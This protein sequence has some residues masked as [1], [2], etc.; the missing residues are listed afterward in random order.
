MN[1]Q[2][3][4]DLAEEFVAVRQHPERQDEIPDINALVEKNI[5]QS[6]DPSAAASE[7]LQ[8]VT[9]LLTPQTTNRDTQIILDATIITTKAIAETLR[10]KPP[11]VLDP[12]STTIEYGQDGLVELPGFNPR[13]KFG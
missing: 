10:V 7:I 6:K 1:T 4:H 13:A 8:K 5:V 2:T 11:P 12:H 3:L 9:A